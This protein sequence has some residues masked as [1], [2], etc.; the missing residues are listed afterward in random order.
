MQ[1]SEDGAADA[2]AAQDTDELAGVDAL[3]AGN[4]VLS[5]KV[6]QGALLAPVAAVGRQF[7]ND[8][9]G[10]PGA[11]RFE[12]D[13]VGAV[14]VDE[15]VGEGDDLSPIGGVGGYLLIAGHAGVEDQLAG[16]VGRGAESV[17]EEVFAA[18][19]REDGAGFSSQRNR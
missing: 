3:D 14:V 7:T 16:G 19:K 18:L 15:G 9:G 4:L 6:V 17:T 12:I 1:A 8:Q 13:S 10:D 5:Q 2:A 11:A